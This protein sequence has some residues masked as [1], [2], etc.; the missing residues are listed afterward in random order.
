MRASAGGPGWP[1]AALVVALLL[2]GVAQSACSGAGADPEIVWLPL[3]GETFSLELA[4][5]SETRRRGL[6]GRESIPPNGGMLFVQPRPGLLAMVMRHCPVAIDVAFLDASGRVL[7][8]HEMR[9]EPPRRSDE[10]PFEYESRLPVYGSGV[11]AQFAVETAG[12]RL[13]QVGLEL[14]D[15]VALDADAL[16][17][18]A[19]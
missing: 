8:I 9:V 1:R 7:A 11:P 2:G 17:R 12:G 13:R 4:L 18:R 6:S 15:R 3:G 14:G 5:D 19:H 10:S 16:T